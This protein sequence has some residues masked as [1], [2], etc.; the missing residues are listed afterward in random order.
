LDTIKTLIKTFRRKLEEMFA[1]AQ[2]PHLNSSK[3]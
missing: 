2:T 3:V 1:R